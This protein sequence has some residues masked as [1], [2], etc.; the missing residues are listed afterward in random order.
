MA[1]ASPHRCTS[2]AQIP[3]NARVHAQLLEGSRIIWI[4]SITATSSGVT[5]YSCFPSLLQDEIN[6]GRIDNRWSQAG[7]CNGYSQ[8]TTNTHHPK[9]FLPSATVVAERLCF[10]RYLSVPLQADIPQV[11]PGKTPPLLGRHPPPRD[12][13][14]SA[15]YTSYWN[16][17]LI[18]F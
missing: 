13:H 18:I 6:I 15:R 8:P 11:P 12:G 3:S 5:N 16:A 17:F 14:C 9:V 10:H 1:D 2:F 7:D 4:S